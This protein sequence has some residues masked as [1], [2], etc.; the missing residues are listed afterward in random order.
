MET[1][2]DAITYRFRLRLITIAGTGCACAF[3]VGASEWTLE[4]TF[5]ERATREHGSVLTQRGRCTTSTGDTASFVVNDEQGGRASGLR[6]FA[7][8]TR[9]SST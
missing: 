9:S 4:C 3:R 5:E 2:S 1:I 8:R 7:G 6:A